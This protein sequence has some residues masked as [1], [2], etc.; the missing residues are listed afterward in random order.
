MAN[1]LENTPKSSKK[2]FIG[3][4]SEPRVQRS[5]AGSTVALSS[6]LGFLGLDLKKELEIRLRDPRIILNEF[7][8][9]LSFVTGLITAFI[10]AFH[11]DAIENIFIADAVNPIFQIFS[12]TN[13][14]ISLYNFFNGVMLTSCAL[15][16]LPLLMVYMPQW[17]VLLTTG[18][19]GIVYTNQ[20]ATLPIGNAFREGL[21]VG[22]IKVDYSYEALVKYHP[23]KYPFEGVLLKGMN[24]FKNLGAYLS[25]VIR[26]ML[27]RSGEMLG[28]IKSGNWKAFVKDPIRSQFF[29]SLM[30]IISA[31]P[32]F[33]I[34]VFE[35][36]AYFGYFVKT[37][38]YNN[39]AHIW[40]TIS[41]RAL[42]FSSFIDGLSKIAFG[43]M[44]ESI[45]M[46]IGGSVFAFAQFYLMFAGEDSLRLVIPLSLAG[47]AAYPI[48]EG[49]RLRKLALEK[50]SNK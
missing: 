23:E 48:V 15:Q 27:I 24:F 35:A 2:P 7:F 44:R 14:Q 22:M 17:R 33:V 9:Y 30:R 1:K 28:E 6:S 21:F 45:M 49:E 37:Q 31:T 32:L 43:F 11:F 50:A 10:V 12:K 20:Y 13:N 3:D 38:D 18:I 5:E 26:E 42:A 41:V 8:G 29:S 46:R 16:N 40:T 47:L 25:T 34:A 19:L 39:A 4:S 36:L